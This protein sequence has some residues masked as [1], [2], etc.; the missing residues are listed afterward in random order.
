VG[1]AKRPK[2]CPTSPVRQTP[3]IPLDANQKRIRQHDDPFF[4]NRLPG[5]GEYTD[6]IH[7]QWLHRIGGGIVF[8]ATVAHGIYYHFETQATSFYTP[9]MGIEEA[10]EE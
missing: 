6:G 5:I 8:V 4:P 2:R 7:L 3:T 1:L 9:T 10:A